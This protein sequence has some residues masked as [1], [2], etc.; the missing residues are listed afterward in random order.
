MLSGWLT[1]IDDIRHCTQTVYTID[2]SSKR[3][4]VARTIGFMSE[5]LSLYLIYLCR[6]R[7]G[8]PRYRGSIPDEAREF[9]S[10]NRPYRPR[11]PPSLLF[12]TFRWIFPWVWSG[13]GREA[14]NSSASSVQFKNDWSYTLT[15]AV[16]I[17][18]VHWATLPFT[19]KVSSLTLKEERSPR[20]LANRLLRRIFVSKRRK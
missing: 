13:S 16:W 10:P 7:A 15:P 20:R 9:P 18:G 17:Y 11:Y 6:L 12:S 19:F 1:Y 3:S 8:R 14:G 4:A 5:E 2:Q